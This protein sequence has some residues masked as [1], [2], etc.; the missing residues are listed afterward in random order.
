MHLGGIDILLYAPAGECVV[1]VLLRACKELWEGSAVCFQDGGATEVR[2]EW[3]L[4][5]PYHFASSSFRAWT[6][7]LFSRSYG[8]GRRLSARGSFGGKS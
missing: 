5:S 7:G 1:D 2:S 6:R 3:H 8:F 4:L